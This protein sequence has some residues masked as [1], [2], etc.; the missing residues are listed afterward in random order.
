VRFF[1]VSER[2][3]AEGTGRGV[4]CFVSNHSWLSFPSYV[5]MRKRMLAEFDRIWVDNL[6][7]SKFE[8]GKVAPDGSPDPSVFS[9]DSNREGI[10]VGTAVALLV[11]RDGG[12]SG[13]Q[14]LYRDLWG[15]AKREA[16]LESLDATDF[17]ESYSEV[18]PTAANRF[19][20][21]RSDVAADYES[22]S[23]LPQLAAQNA[24]PGLQELRNEALIDQD[25]KDLTIRI[26]RYCDPNETFLSLREDDCGPVR[27]MARFD[28]AKARQTLLKAER[29]RDSNVRR[30]H[31]RAFEESWCYHTTTRPIWNDP[32]PELAAIIGPDNP[33]PVS[34]A[35]R[36]RP[37]EGPH[38]LLTTA[39]PDYHLLRPNCSAITYFRADKSANLSPAARAWLAAIGLLDPDAN[40]VIAAL[41]S[42]HALAIGYAP[43]WL[44][45]NGDGIRQDWPRVPLP[46]NADL[47]RASA[48]LGARV[49]ALLDPDTPVSGVT[50]GAIQP[51]IATIAVPAK[52][53]GGAMTQADRLLTAGW[54][55]AGKGGA[56]MPGRGRSAARDY[57]EIEAPARAEAA[58]LGAT[59][60]DVFL[61][62]DAY[63]RNIPETVWSF[64]IGGYQVLKKWLS[65]REQPLLGRA[66][67]PGE[68]RY[69]RDVAR[70]LA[71]LRLMAP[72]LDANYRACAAAHR[73]LDAA[74]ANPNA[75]AV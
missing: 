58:L 45:E 48:A 24:M 37:N 9:T 7:G 42:H 72:E 75:G 34:R 74:V 69:V 64:T 14:V 16:L 32:R 26:Q 63:W 29:F 68:V 56:V 44:S 13:G 40:H 19:V 59:T 3:I 10:Q 38:I 22:W 25:W 2:R 12:D 18:Q 66:L 27:D 51:V 71:A 54:G 21:R 17:D 39:L 30:Y 41:P 52:R 28:A 55:H 50:T 20:V 4:V 62:L 60:L 6:N 47:L 5:V 43:A 23:L 1:R 49:A 11:K 35:Y 70:R 53:G 31:Q 73:P 8:T 15:V 61:N 33:A 57:I 65:Y 67:T 36:E 46:D